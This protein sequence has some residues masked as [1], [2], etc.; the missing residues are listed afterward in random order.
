[1]H[2][3]AGEAEFDSE[4]TSQIACGLSL[5]D[6]TLRFVRL[7]IM[8]SMKSLSSEPIYILRILSDL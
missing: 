6:N 1:M 5:S 3:D 2:G 8:G 7:S 4:M